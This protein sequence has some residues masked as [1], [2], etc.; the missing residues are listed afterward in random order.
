MTVI[1]EKSGPVTTIVMSR[2]EV[3]NA[4]DPATAR[5]LHRSFLAF[6]ADPE[7]SVA[8]FHGA[9]GSFCA[10]YDLKALAAGEGADWAEAIGFPDD[11]LEPN[12]IGPMG[13]SR[14]ELSKPVI[15][16]VEGP[17]VAGGTELALWCDFR[18]MAEDAFFGIYCRRWGVP[19]IDGGTVRLPR[20][21]GMGRALEIIL[22]GRKVP[23]EEALRIGLC[24][25]VVPHG[26]TRAKAEALAHEIA[27]FPQ[28]CVR[29]DRASAHRQQGLAERE[30]LRVEFGGSLPVIRA[31]S[32]GG[33]G[34]FAGGLGRHGD[35]RKI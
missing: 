6:E 23:A 28:A 13:V 22:T 14:L 31:E 20:L 3:K 30:A 24:E 1:V 26:E 7:A 33:A 32:V 16:A 15:A 18:V 29:A 34:R 21:V 10:G 35:Y 5:E 9:H 4:V 19:L 27:R 8:V 25:Y 17:A 11:R 2:P 12:P